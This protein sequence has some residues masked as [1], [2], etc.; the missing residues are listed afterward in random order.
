MLVASGFFYST[1]PQAQHPNIPKNMSDKKT[2][3]N[4][5]IPIKR[6]PSHK[7]LTKTLFQAE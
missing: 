7:V 5:A 4:V 1:I 2:I 3:P 6:T